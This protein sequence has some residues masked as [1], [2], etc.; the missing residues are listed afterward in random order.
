M[1]TTTTVVAVIPVALGFA[2]HEF[3]LQPLAVTIM[4]GVLFLVPVLITMLEEDGGH[5]FKK[6]Q[7]MRNLLFNTSFGG[8]LKL[9]FKKF[10]HRYLV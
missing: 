10:Y 5:I 9:R 4:F 3:Y 1:M 2:G 8:N 7:H 6:S